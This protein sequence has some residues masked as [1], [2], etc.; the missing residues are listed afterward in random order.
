M[1]AVECCWDPIETESPDLRSCR[2]KSAQLLRQRE[3]APIAGVFHSEYNLFGTGKLH[4]DVAQLYHPWRAIFRQLAKI[5]VNI[6]D[7]L[8]E[9][10]LSERQ[11][12]ANL[13]HPNIT[14]LLDGGT[15]LNGIPYVVIEFVARQSAWL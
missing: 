12:L 9:R 2:D 11:I 14:R 4:L 13:N 7:V 6:F 15:T 10:F 1:E 5:C 8:D 3:S